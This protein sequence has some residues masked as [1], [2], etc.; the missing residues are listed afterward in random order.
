MGLKA[1][2]FFWGLAEATLFFIVPDVLISAAALRDRALALRLCLWA[3]GGALGGGLIMYL[4]GDRNVE[5]ISQVLEHVPAIGKAML[6]R[7][8]TDLAQLG[9]LATF[10]GPLTGTPYKIY[11]AL[12]PE[13]GISLTAF[14]LISIPARVIRFVLVAWVTSWI[15]GIL[16]RGW[17]Y[18]I[19]L[20]LL[21][22]LWAAF[23]LGYFLLM[24]GS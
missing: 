19:R 15:A 13:A 12:S 22:T 18:R 5:Q 4:W 21:L 9:S 20:L 6:T 10:L 1:A 11:A 14:L 17:S 8:S 24:S 3:L 23:Y 7:V 2:A 16:L